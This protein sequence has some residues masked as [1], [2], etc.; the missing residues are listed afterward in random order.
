[1]SAE[2]LAALAEDSPFPDYVSDD[3]DD[4][5]GTSTVS[6]EG[7]S[8][9]TPAAEKRSR[10]SRRGRRRS[11]PE[12]VIEK[13]DSEPEELAEDQTL[14]LPT[15]VLEELM[16]DVLEGAPVPGPAFE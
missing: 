1:M 7:E 13:Q 3:D 10:R 5:D 4:E 14:M 6:G 16:A 15:D 12:T 8:V 2:E 11:G 9:E